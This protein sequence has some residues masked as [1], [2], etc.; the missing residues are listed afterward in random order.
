MWRKFLPLLDEMITSD[1]TRKR[2]K[3]REMENKSEDYYSPKD[4]SSSSTKQLEKMLGWNYAY[5]RKNKLVKVEFIIPP[6]AITNVEKKDVFDCRHAIFR[7]NKAIVKKIYGGKVAQ[8][9]PYISYVEDPYCTVSIG[10]P[11]IR[12][13]E[14]ETI[15]I[16]DFDMN[17]DKVK[18]NGCY[19]FLDEKAVDERFI[20]LTNYTGVHRIW[21]YNGRICAEITYLNGEKHGP[22]TVWYDNGQISLQSCMNHGSLNG[23]YKTWYSNGN[24]RA[25]LINN[26]GSAYGPA[27]YWYKNGVRRERCTYKYTTVVGLYEKWDETGKLIKSTFYPHYELRSMAKKSFWIPFIPNKRLK[28]F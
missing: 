26:D 7:T 19:F 24:M 13:V 27:E 11:L 10:L 22:Y 2:D 15:V 18:G 17:L 4:L 16:D 1:E 14:G 6:E 20:S 12:Y 23:P 5:Y 9:I 21:H 28:R 25:S 3:K 8:S